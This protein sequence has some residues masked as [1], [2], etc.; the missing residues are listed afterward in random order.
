MAL[1]IAVFGA[2]S[3]GCHLGGALAADCGVTLVGRPSAMDAVRE[4]GLLL[5][6]GG[7]PE[8]R[9]A[10][11]R[12]RTSADP[13]AV[14]GADYVLVTVKSGATREAARA[15]GPHLRAG[16]VVVSFQNGL[17]NPAEL[18]AA[19][20][21]GTAVLA[22]MVPYNVVR[23][24]PASFHQGT[25]G[26]L[27][28]DDVT[29]AR[30]LVA[31]LRRAGLAVEPRG[32]MPRVQHAKLLMNLNNAVNALSGLP[33]R[34][35][36]GSRAY[37]RCLALC[38]EEAL[39]VFRAEGVVPARLGPVPASVTP[40]LLRWPDAV[41]RRVAAASLRVDAQ[42][43]SSMWEDLERGRPT[44]IDS[45]QGEVVA[46]AARHGLGAPVNARLAELVREAEAEAV[47]GR[48]RRWTGAE[49]YAE[50]AAAARRG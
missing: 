19:L 49:L 27:M 23:T 15:I 14:A 2:G 33:L 28:V 3:I 29:A 38:Q 24:G 25:V 7:R 21:A 11:E 48:P 20:P 16:T 30:P 41:F 9:I 1:E 44:E 4:R 39:A 43:R 12:L 13:A 31:A 40:R 45:L 22:G 18:R 47:A 10:P 35:Q 26:A 42:A 5:T 37:R 34:E 36:L 6:G 32:D 50:V 8:A 46:L 17:R